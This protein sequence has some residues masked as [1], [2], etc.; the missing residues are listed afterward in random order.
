MLGGISVS[1]QE[2]YYLKA[3]AALLIF[4]ELFKGLTHIISL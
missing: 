3:L 4:R 1:N 2:S